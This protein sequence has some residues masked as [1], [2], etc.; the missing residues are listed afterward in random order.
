MAVEGAKD[1]ADVDIEILDHGRVRGIALH[2]AP[3]QPFAAQVLATEGFAFDDHIRLVQ[4]E[5]R[6][7]AAVFLNQLGRRLDRNVDGVMGQI[8]EERPFGIAFVD[9]PNGLR[10][11][12]VSEVL[13]VRPIRQIR[14]AVGTEE[15]ILRHAPAEA[16]NV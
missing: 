10:G 15:A 11:E 2:G 5:F 12:P 6:R 9:Q 14:H 13:A 7:L 4:A 1:A 8:E 3:E 16:G